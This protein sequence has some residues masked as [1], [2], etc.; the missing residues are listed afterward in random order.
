MRLGTLVPTIISTMGHVM[1]CEASSPSGFLVP[2]NG[3]VVENIGTTPG[4]SNTCAT[5]HVA[6]SSSNKN[7]ILSGIKLLE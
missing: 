2:K 1:A 7:I 3:K 6:T 4:N 5:G